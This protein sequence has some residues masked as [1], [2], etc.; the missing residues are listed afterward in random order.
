MRRGY[1]TPRGRAI[2]VGAVIAIAAASVWA[3]WPSPR[4]PAAFCAPVSRLVGADAEATLAIPYTDALTGPTRATV[5]RLVADAALS[6]R[7]P[8]TSELGRR[9]RE[10]ATDLRRDATLLAV[11]D[12]VSAFDGWAAHHLAGCGIRPIGHP[13]G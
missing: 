11:T 7:R 6:A 2:I 12:T 13:I 5:N 9:L 10:Y 3:A 1:A 8:P 4:W